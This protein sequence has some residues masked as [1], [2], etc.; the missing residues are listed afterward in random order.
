MKVALL[1]YLD[2]TV[3]FLLCWTVG[4][5]RYLWRCDR[6]AP[7][8]TGDEAIR[9][10][11]VIRP[12]G[13]GD[14]VLLL[15]TLRSLRRRFP[16]VVIH[17]VCEKRNREIL[18]LAGVA[19]ETLVYDANPVAFAGKLAQGRYD[20]AIDTEQFHYFSALMALFSRAPVRIG[21]KISPGRNLLYSH[22]VNYDL[23]GY[24]ADQFMRLLGPLGIVGGAAVVGCLSADPNAIPNEILG[25]LRPFESAGR[26]VAIH[27]GSTS[28]YKLWAPEKVAG[29]ITRLAEDPTL[30]FVLL[31]SPG[32]RRPTEAVL[33]QI[34]LEGR[35]F[36]LAGQLTVAQSAAVIRRCALYAGGDSGLAHVAVALGIP[37]V[38]WFGPSDSQKWG[39]SDRR[40]RVVRKPLACAPCSI[41]GYHKLCRTIDCMQAIAVED[42]LH[43]CEAILAG[44]ER[45]G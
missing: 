33:R 18:R 5:W 42:V 21:F 27:A 22:L 2:A 13:L 19:D 40:H 24:E 4:W 26:L 35:V 41:F 3:G 12:G 16:G 7:A 32:E 31:G 28:R 11:V 17:I 14:M 30:A 37:T 34:R 9:R 36:S 8:L 43:A 29:L 1:K 6:P 45:I 15:P 10:I 39:V 44:G 20:V 23:E 25:K 38:V